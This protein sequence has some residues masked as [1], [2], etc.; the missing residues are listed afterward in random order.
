MGLIRTLVDRP[1][2]STM[3]VVAL[4]VMGL[5]GYVKLNLELIPRVDYPVIVV[6]T[7]YPGASPAEVESQI[8]KRIE[9]Q[10]ATIANIE[11]LV[12]ESR[13]SVSIVTIQFSL[14][15]TQDQGAIDVK[16]KVDAIRGDLPEAAEDPVIAKFELGGGAVAQIALSAP[17]PMDEIYRVADEVIKDRLSRIDG[18]AGVVITGKR[19]REIRV[20]VKPERLRAYGLTLGG[21]RQVLQAGNVTIPAGNITRGGH[22]VTLRLKGEITRP[23][24]LES[25][26][27]PLPTGGTIVLSEV[28]DII[29]TTEELREFTTLNRQEVI[30][31]NVMKRSDG[32]TVKVVDGVET[33]LADLRD[34]LG[35][36]YTIDIV[37]EGRSFVQDSVDD[38]IRNIGIGILLTGVLLFVFL[39]DWRQTLIA[40]LAMPVSVIAT[41]MLME[42]SGFTLNVMTLMALGISIGTLVTNSIVV[43][44]SI[45]RHIGDGE[46]PHE[47]A[48]IG[49]QEVALAVFASTLTNIVVFTPIAFMSGIIGRFFLQFGLTVVFATV[50]SLVVSFSLVPMLAARLLRPGKGIGSGGSAAARM[51]QA[52]DRFYGR[53]ENNYRQALGFVLKHRWQPLLG[54]T[55][56]LAGSLYLFGWIGGEF[57]PVTDQSKLLIQVE[58]PE[59]TSLQRSREVAALIENVLWREP[60][61]SAVLVRAGGG[62]LGVEDLEILVRMVPPAER[63]VTLLDFIT[64]VR[65]GLAIVP[66][67]KIN[68]VA[69][70]EGKRPEPELIL[71]VLG[72]NPLTREKAADTLFE[73]MRGIPDLV[74]VASSQAM[75]KPQIEFIPRR[76]QLAAHGL[77]AAQVG[78]DLRI[79]YEGE[80]AGVF[81]QGGEEFDI[82]VRYPESSRQD[83]ADLA[84]LPV[85]SRSGYTVPLADVAEMVESVGTPTLFRAD[86]QRKI[87][88]TANIGAGNLSGMRKAIDNGL[89]DAVIADDVTIQ[90]SGSAEHQDEAFASIIGALILAIILIYIV[91]AAMLE[92]FIHPLTVMVTLPLGLIGLAVALFFTGRTINIFSLMAMIMLIGIVVNNAILLL[93]Y[94]GQLRARGMTLTE[95]LLKACPTRLRP[96]IMANLA[97]AV[98]M[99]PQAMGGAGSEFRT[100]MA[101]VQIGGVLISAVFTLFVIPIVYS[102]FDKL[103]FAGRKSKKTG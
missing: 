38:V 65:P 37:T 60:E 77:T 27:I 90:Y 44:E 72:D 40:S 79:A 5:N 64:R 14:D 59:G 78:L 92:S 96:I 52:W 94:T 67:A 9:D 20:T 43:L 12:S 55:L 21:L 81:R 97:I 74:D 88:V 24:D 32:N 63:E 6:T 73:I 95:A 4:V 10:V 15:V 76:L 22:E 45:A 25:F 16:D 26:R 42:S 31:I 86:K 48:I 61:V 23:I 83:P 85:A 35:S 50:F 66:D 41:F 101:V 17:R 56:L 75:G 98:G 93:D 7:V 11:E 34:E 70:G 62:Q 51:A 99:M 89:A 71:E 82:V 80:N 3:I 18:V 1:V 68:I 13:Q 30:G 54:T 102:M 8:T 49:T 87:E 100:P 53:L 2:L 19:E 46:T 29:D 69:S 84:D 91:M 39:H 36:D 57:I 47:A 28:A 103:T 33:V 58:L